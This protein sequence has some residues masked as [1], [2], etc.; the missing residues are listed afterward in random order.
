MSGSELLNESN[1]LLSVAEGDTQAFRLLFDHYRP[2]IYSYALHLTESSSHA[3]EVVQEV[4]LKLWTNRQSLRQV[5]SFNGW[6]YAVARHCIFDAFKKTAKEARAMKEIGEAGAVASNN[7]DDLILERENE[8]L[9]QKALSMLS[10]QQQTIYYLSRH[11]GMKH[12]EIAKEL[13]ISK[14]TVKVHM[15]NALKAIR[16]YVSKNPDYMW[17]IFCFFLTRR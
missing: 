12:E 13:S 1:I 15:V 10:P 14:N 2:K 11:R 8:Q 5:E 6:L 3:D 9:L 16:E 4:F 17:I 7:V